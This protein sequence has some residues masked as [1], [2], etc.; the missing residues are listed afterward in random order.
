MIITDKI[1]AMLLK[2]LK[3]ATRSERETLGK[4]IAYFSTSE[5]V[6]MAYNVVWGHA[7]V[8]SDQQNAELPA[9]Y[10]SFD[11]LKEVIHDLEQWDEKSEFSAEKQR[12][13]D[14]F[15]DKLFLFSTATKLLINEP[16]NIEKTFDKNVYKLTSHHES[17]YYVLTK[18]TLKRNLATFIRPGVVYFIGA[19]IPGVSSEEGH[20]HAVCVYK[21]KTTGKFYYHDSA[22]ADVEVEANDLTDL[23]DKLWASTSR[24]RFAASTVESSADHLRKLKISAFKFNNDSYYD[25][26]LYAHELRA[27]GQ[28][29]ELASQYLDADHLMNDPLG[30]EWVLKLSDPAV[31][32]I[33]EKQDDVSK[34]LQQQVIDSAITHINERSPVVAR[35]LCKKLA[36]LQPSEVGKKANEAMDPLPRTY[37]STDDDEARNYM[38]T[39]VYAFQHGLLQEKDKSKIYLNDALIVLK[40]HGDVP[41]LIDELFTRI[42]L[43][44]YVSEQPAIV[45]RD[46][47]E[48][49][50]SETRYAV[51]TPIVEDTYRRRYYYEY[52]HSD[53]LYRELECGLEN[54][55]RANIEKGRV[56]IA[57]QL[58]QAVSR[59]TIVPV[60]DRRR[61]LEQ[62]MPE[63][64][65]YLS[66][67]TI[68]QI[69]NPEFS[70]FMRENF[71]AA[72]GYVPESRDDLVRKT[73]FASYKSMAAQMHQSSASLL[74]RENTLTSLELKKLAEEDQD[75]DSALSHAYK[76]LPFNYKW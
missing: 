58:M 57:K 72:Y 61:S 35:A 11:T 25:H 52:G 23:I 17:K 34:A 3:S 53:K 39:W 40:R 18:E 68:G 22:Q 42:E 26:Y 46:P 73:F 50:R 12:K 36:R 41:G 1:L 15:I 76:G 21:G 20:K 9:Q 44:Y 60:S 19:D 27:N 54:A 70:A 30:K 37:Y 5:N 8:V 47:K 63:M 31:A 7:R 16:G 2:K 51:R 64:P 67:L 45:W 38:D 66:A 49:E 65:K 4:M 6:P 24:S 43:P 71:S 14:Q 29:Y 74:A 48:Q 55:I 62:E 13:I 69:N 56:D 10:L 28:E 32:Q 75:P 59:L 33:I